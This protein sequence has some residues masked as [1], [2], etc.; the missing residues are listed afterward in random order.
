MVRDVIFLCASDWEKGKLIHAACPV[1]PPPTMSAPQRTT[2][3]MLSFGTP[4]Q[5]D[6]CA[7]AILVPGEPA[8]AFAQ[9]LLVRFAMYSGR[10]T[11]LYASG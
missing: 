2:R 3:I 9:M 8:A 11:E 6:C 1:A 7:L 5:R 10:L 4:V